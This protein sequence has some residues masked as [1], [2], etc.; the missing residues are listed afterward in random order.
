LAYFAKSTLSRARAAYH[1]L[2]SIQPVYRFDELI[3][4]LR[5]MILPLEKMDLKYRMSLVQMAQEHD[6][7]DPSVFRPEEDGYVQRW[8]QTA[9]QERFI[10]GN[11]IELKQKLE[12]LKIRECVFYLILLMLG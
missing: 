3:E 2:E 1:D 10:R 6:V 9:F 4:F 11:D 7:D 8:R 5:R 12:E